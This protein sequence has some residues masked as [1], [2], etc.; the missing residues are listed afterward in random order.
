MHGLETA[1]QKIAKCLVVSLA[2]GTP[3]RSFGHA[4]LKT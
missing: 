1:Q 4:F 3:V 2:N